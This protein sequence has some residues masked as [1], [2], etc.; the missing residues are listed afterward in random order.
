MEPLGYARW[1]NFQ[2]AINRAIESCETTAYRAGD[3]FRGVTK[4]VKLGSSAE[5]AIED[6][7]LSGAVR[8]L[9]D[10]GLLA[11]KGRGSATYYVPTERAGPRWRWLVDQAAGLVYQPLWLI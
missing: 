6:F 2:T 9:R 1:E 10:A 11:Q 4:M 5:R 7:M 3:H 8:R